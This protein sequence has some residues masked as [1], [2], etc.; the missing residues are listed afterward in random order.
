MTDQQSNSSTTC[1]PKE[2]LLVSDAVSR[3]AEGMWGGLP[4][5][6]PV[7][8]VKRGYRKMSVGFANWRVRAGQQLMQSALRGE[9]TIYVFVS[10]RI[11]SKKHSV[12]HA[13]SRATELLSAAI[14]VKVL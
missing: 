13:S 6:L 14:P 11:A 9:L 8:R 10:T 5:P 7:E 3:L 12:A 1:V 2:F 4:R